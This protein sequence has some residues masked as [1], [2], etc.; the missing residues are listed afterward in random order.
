MELLLLIAAL[1]LFLVLYCIQSFKIKS[2]ERMVSRMNEEE[3]PVDSG[4][5]VHDELL[6]SM[7][8]IDIAP[9]SRV[10]TYVQSD[11]KDNDRL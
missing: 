9:E 10:E 4:G 7:H 2:I 1:A 6:E 11:S 5:I 8:V 3:R